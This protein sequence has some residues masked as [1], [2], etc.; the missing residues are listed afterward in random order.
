MINRVSKRGP[1]LVY[2]AVRGSRSTFASG[3][4]LSGC[5]RTR[6]CKF[7]Q[8]PSRQQYAT[9]VAC[10]HITDK[11]RNIIGNLNIFDAYNESQ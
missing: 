7:I 5:G 10:A 3:E 11:D 8:T 4:R 1:R 2:T 6:L 9:C